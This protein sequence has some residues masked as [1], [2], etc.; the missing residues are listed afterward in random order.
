MYPTHNEGKPIVAERF[1]STLKNKIYRHMT[2]AS[3][4][5]YFE[6]LDDIVDKY[7]SAYHRTIKMKPIDVNFDSYAEYN[8]NSNA[9]ITQFKIGDHVRISKY[10]NIFAPQLV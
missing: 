9:K 10:K 3:K 7:N 4:N 1:I 8:I 6:V 2:A 5:V